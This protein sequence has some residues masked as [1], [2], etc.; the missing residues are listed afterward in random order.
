MAGEY[1]GLARIMFSIVDV[2]DVATAHLTAM[3]SPTAAGKRYLCAVDALWFQEMCEILQRHFAN[4]GY[5]IPTRQL[6]DIFVRL[7][8]LF[9][10]SARSVID[11]LG[12][13]IK[14]SN[15]RIIQELNWKP[16]SAEEA[17]VAMA[18]SLIQHGI[19]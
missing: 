18:E 6:P 16:R 9:D 15:Q 3:T 8:A 1:P 5:K 4:Q 19:V 17:I 2:R 11:D 12:R 10:K 13:E 7:F 14:F